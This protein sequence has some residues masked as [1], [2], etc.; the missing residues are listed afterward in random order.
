MRPLFVT[1]FPS[2]FLY[3]WSPYC[4]PSI[5]KGTLLYRLNF[6]CAWSRLKAHDPLKKVWNWT[7]CWFYEVQTQKGSNKCLFILTQIFSMQ[8]F[9]FCWLYKVTF[10]DTITNTLV[11]WAH[12]C[13]VHSFPTLCFDCHPDVFGVMDR[14]PRSTQFWVRHWK[15]CIWILI[16]FCYLLFSS[17]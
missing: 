16:D 11:S 13:I 2:L 3:L 5:F 1:F 10:L 4:G 14:T 7:C 15:K 17:L 9:D 12:Y 8:I 6:S